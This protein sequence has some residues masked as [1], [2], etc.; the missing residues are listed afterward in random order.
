MQVCTDTYIT[1]TLV[2]MH[3]HTHKHTQLD[4]HKAQHENSLEVNV[5]CVLYSGKLRVKREDTSM[6]AWRQLTTIELMLAMHVVVH[7]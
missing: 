7:R 5:Q 1:S 2:C 4:G 6:S 3:A